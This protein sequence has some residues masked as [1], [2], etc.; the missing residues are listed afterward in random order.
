V[1]NVLLIYWRASEGEKPS[2]S[3]L[4][5]LFIEEGFHDFEVDGLLDWYAAEYDFARERLAWKTAG[6][7]IPGPTRAQLRAW[8]K[9]RSTTSSPTSADSPAT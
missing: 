2:E 3:F 5:G 1:N 8:R 9:E 4:V 7:V 6:T